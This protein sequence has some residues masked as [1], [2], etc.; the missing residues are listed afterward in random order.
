MGETGRRFCEENK[1]AWLDLSGNAYIKAPGLLIHVEG[2][3]N[4]YKKV[5]RPPNLFAPKSSRI[6]RYFL[7]QPYRPLNQRDLARA[8]NLDEGYTSRLVRR[9]EENGLVARDEK[10]LLNPKDPE[11]L[12]DAW[13]DAYDFMKHNI[14]RGHVAARS[15]DELLHRVAEILDREHVDYAATGLGA[16]WLFTHFANFRLATF[17][18]NQF[19]AD[20]LFPE[21]GFS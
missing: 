7:I 5:G 18:L 10:G 16:A 3:P 14:I 8:T 19:P 11:H 15:G 1:I 21:L 20:N 13:H 12:L 6:V 9:F 2:K 4:R 17:Y